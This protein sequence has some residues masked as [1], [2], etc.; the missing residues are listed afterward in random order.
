MNQRTITVL[1][2]SCLAVRWQSLPFQERSNGTVFPLRNDSES[3]SGSNS[4]PCSRVATLFATKQ[5]RQYTYN[6]TLRRVRITIVVCTLVVTPGRL[7][8]RYQDFKLTYTEDVACRL[9]QKHRYL[10]TDLYGVTPQ[11][12]AIISAIVRT[13]ER[14]ILNAVEMAGRTWYAT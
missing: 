2:L 1:W 13:W 11:Q 8:Y 7:V 6:V 3:K 5:Q 9:D 12:F 14:L 4:F 10:H